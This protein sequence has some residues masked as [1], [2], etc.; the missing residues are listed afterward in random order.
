MDKYNR[1]IPFSEID[2]LLDYAFAELS[3]VE[4]V[5]LCEN[6]IKDIKR[7][8]HMPTS[9]QPEIVRCRDCKRY[10]TEYCYMATDF[11]GLKPDDYCS[12]G[13]RYD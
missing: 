5:E 8:I 11:A 7:H 13:E 9:D 2:V 1:A 4:Y 10:E 6:I 3:D 12:Y